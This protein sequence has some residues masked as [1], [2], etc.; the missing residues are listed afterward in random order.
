MQIR[1]CSRPVPVRAQ[2]PKWFGGEKGRRVL[3]VPHDVGAAALALGTEGT[4]LLHSC[5]SAAQCST[6]WRPR[7]P[8]VETWQDG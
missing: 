4:R 8:R 5:F 6:S 2:I 3:G 7:G 1:A